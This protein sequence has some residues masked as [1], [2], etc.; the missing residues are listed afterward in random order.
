[1]PFYA[2]LHSSTPYAYLES[3]FSKPVRTAAAALFMLRVSFYLAVV[4]QA[5]AIILEESG[6][7]P[8]WITV[9]ICGV[10]ATVFTMKGGMKTVILTDFMQSIALLG[11][12]ILTLIFAVAG[13]EESS[14]SVIDEDIKL[15]WAT[16]M[17]IQSWYKDNLWYFLIGSTFS[18]VAGAGTDQIAI[19]RFMSITNLSDA[20]RAS[21]YTG[22]LNG[23]ITL[24]LG[25]TGLYIHAFYRERNYDP[26]AEDPNANKIMFIF[27]LEHSIPGLVGVVFSAVL[28]CTLSVVCGGLNAAAT[29]FY[30]D[31]L[32]NSFRWK[33]TPAQVVSVSR[34]VTAAFGAF[35]TLIAAFST[36]VHMDI[37][38]FSNSVSGL[39]GG[40]VC[41]VF[42]C[43]MSTKLARTEGMILGFGVAFLLI[44]YVITGE[45]FCRKTPQ[46]DIPSVCQED[47]FFY[48]ARINPWMIS[49]WL[50][51]ATALCG[52]VVSFLLQLSRKQR[53]V[54]EIL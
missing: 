10:F 43:G 5:P 46:H 17:S 25:C 50:G 44:S 47:E 18:Y 8:P 7:V 11:G 33:A 20:Q 19:Q 32:E 24:L 21:I 38:N 48:Y 28:G 3:R 54:E 36:M 13:S 27:L 51:T 2:R 16:F 35:V 41:A 30:V 52:V 37:I 49:F 29:S 23:A 53:I 14:P 40:P 26:T 12:A 9:S 34:R 1:M 39:F 4:L 15:R 45:L 31:I 22:W 6:K 42:L